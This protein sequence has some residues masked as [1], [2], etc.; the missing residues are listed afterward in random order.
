[1]G[2][3]KLK[4]KKKKTFVVLVDI[5]ICR[6]HLRKAKIISCDDIPWYL[7]DFPHTVTIVIFMRLTATAL[8][9]LITSIRPY[10]DWGYPISKSAVLIESKIVYAA[11]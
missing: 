3:T 1:M 4:K 5:E 9:G 11:L 8:T 7:E 10:Q 2:G 6:A